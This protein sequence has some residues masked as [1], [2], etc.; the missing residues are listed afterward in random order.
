[1]AQLF[2]LIFKFLHILGAALNFFHYFIIVFIRKFCD[3]FMLYK[4]N[5]LFIFIAV[6]YAIY[7]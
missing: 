3:K 1:M 5:N 4:S 6:I 2:I 7:F